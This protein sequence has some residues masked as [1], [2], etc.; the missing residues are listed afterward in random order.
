M[1]N[2]VNKPLILKIEEAKIEL[3]KDV[4]EVVRKYGLSCY[5]IE[6]IIANLYR[7]VQAQAK[8]ELEQVQL[9][10]SA[11]NNEKQNNK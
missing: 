8:A 7:Q 11:Q 4:N 6:P 5:F 2:Q 10:Y 3:T 9:S 1:D